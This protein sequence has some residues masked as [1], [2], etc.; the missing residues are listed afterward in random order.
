MQP[1]SDRQ[2]VPGGTARLPDGRVLVVRPGRPADVPGILALFEG[3]S[4]D[5]RYRRFF[6]GFH[7][8]DE[9]VVALVARP[10]TEGRLLV[11]EVSTPEGSEIVGEAEYAHLADGGAELALTVER[12]WRGWLGSFLLDALLRVADAEGVP[13]LRAEVL[14]QNRSMLAL[15]RSRGCAMVER[16][17]PSVADVVVGAHGA[18]PPWPPGAAHPRVL[19][20]ATGTRWQLT[21][22]LAEAGVPVLRCAGPTARPATAACPVLEGQRCPLADG[23]DVVVHALGRDDPR[24]A[25]VADAHARAGTPLV[26]VGEPGAAE[27]VDAIV[28]QVLDVGSRPTGG[29]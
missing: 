28:A 26:E 24:C 1:G 3:L 8:D 4:P 13:C 18:A 2:A 23:A 22:K 20:E 21:S 16:G 19:L 14:A 6:S 5:D 12:R 11:A 10:V 9:F 15:L 25:A 17:D 27:E 7:P 29:S